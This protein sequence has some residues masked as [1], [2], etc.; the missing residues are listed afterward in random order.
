MDKS[1]FVRAVEDPEWSFPFGEA[2]G[3]EVDDESD[4]LLRA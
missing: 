1:G 3:G 2:Y 4:V